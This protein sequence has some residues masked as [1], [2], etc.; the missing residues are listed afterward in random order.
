MAADTRPLH[1]VSMRGVIVPAM[2][3]FVAVAW[4]ARRNGDEPQAVNPSVDYPYV[5]PASA[6]ATQSGWPGS[7]SGAREGADEAALAEAGAADDSLGKYVDGKYRFLASSEK[8]RAALLA[9]EQIAV[10]INTARQSNDPALTE[11]IPAQLAELA[12]LDQKVGALLRPEDL[13]TF[14]VLKDSD[15]EQFLLD[16]Y[17]GGVNAVA[18]LNEAD[19][20]AILYTKL[21]HRQR[22]RQVLADSRLMSGDLSASERQLVFAD[23]SRS[24]RESRDSY[25]QEVRQYL[26]NDEQF[27]LLSNY[28]NTE[29][30][31]E[32]EKLRGIANGD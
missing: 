18:P 16:D 24:L 27:T 1:S 12:A 9:R 7:A 29:Y 14:D 2:L 23:V 5:N 20:K 6:Q 10:A 19:R 17:A 15:V 4:W 25:L 26:Y 30:A 28:E 13:A 8:L 11:A 21:V 31:A 32:L 22:F 3:V